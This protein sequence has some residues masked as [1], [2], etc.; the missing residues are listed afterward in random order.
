MEFN[1][2]DHIGNFSFVNSVDKSEFDSETQWKYLQ[3][4]AFTQINHGI[5][6]LAVDDESNQV[7]L[8]GSEN[9]GLY[10]PIWRA[11]YGE[12]NMESTIDYQL[13]SI[14]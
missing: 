7:R 14:G 6:A 4:S 3:L 1:T 8:S 10:C 2:A 13:P 12:L 9:L 5:M 11:Q